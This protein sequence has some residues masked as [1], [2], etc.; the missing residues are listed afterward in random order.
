MGAIEYSTRIGDTEMRLTPA[1]QAKLAEMLAEADDEITGIRVF[2]AGGGC[3]GMSYGMTYADSTIDNHYDSVLEGP[4]FK[5]YVDAVAL[6]YL[7][8]CEIDFR[9][10]S[11]VFNK[12][13]QAVGGSGTCG[14]CG[15]GGF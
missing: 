9:D 3:G 14:G 6:N 5:V 8:G 7:Q 11:F 15:G 10:A 13:F 12:V 1:A 2:V 4:G